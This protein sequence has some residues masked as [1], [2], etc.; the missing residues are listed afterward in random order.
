MKKI[1]FIF[2]T[3]PEAIKM[4]PLITEFKNNSKYFK[5][6]ICVTGQHR[7]MLDQVLSFFKIKPDYDLNLMKPGQT[8][9]DITADGLRGCEKVIE[10]L[11]PDLVFVQGDTSTA[12]VGALA[13]FYKKIPVVH[14]EA[15]LRTNDKYSPF[16]EEI[17]RSLI[18]KLANYHFTPT[19]ASSRNLKIEGITKNI[20][21][22]GNTVIDALKM[23]LKILDKNNVNFEDEFGGIDFSRRTILVTGHRRE[24]F[25]QPLNDIC[26]VL[27]Q[28]ANKFPEC[29]LVYPVHLNPQL[30]EVTKK[31]LGKT[32]NIFLIEP[33]D[34]PRLIWLMKKSYLIITDS[35][36]IQEEAPFLGKPVL[37]TRNT[38]E[39]PEGI[40]A[41]TAKL[42]GHNKNKIFKEVKKLLESKSNYNKMSKANNPYGKGDA[43]EKIAKIIKNKICL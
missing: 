33:L 15:G 8:L 7:E 36:G 26:V 23:G 1:L 12:F 27:N 18:S 16:P 29:N 25:G 24:N 31:M 37:V 14:I 30:R 38:T 20:F 35:G 40:K 28:I 2:G 4:V 6:I 34:Y 10:K 42:V 5:V 22:V 32:K 41:G 43:S 13:A 9:F 11:K 17:N 19:V 39:R 3:R 21:C